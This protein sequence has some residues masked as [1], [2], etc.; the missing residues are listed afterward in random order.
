MAAGLEEAGVALSQVGLFALAVGP[1]SFTGLR[2]GLA[3]VQGLAFEGSAPAAPISALEALALAAGGEEA[4]VA[5]LLDARRG[6]VYAAA[7]GP[8]DARPLP[9]GLY[10]AEDLARRLPAGCLL[11]GEGAACHAGL[12]QA[13]GFRSASVAVCAPA[14]AVG[15]L[16]LR[17]FRQGRAQPPGL[18]VPRYLR[19]AEAEARRTGEALEPKNPF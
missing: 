18:V 2:V 15:R 5:A 19:R 14:E 1:G 16:G 3:T 10:R 4:V 7:F 11:T 9:E 8:G 12:L 13:A 17:L 6:D